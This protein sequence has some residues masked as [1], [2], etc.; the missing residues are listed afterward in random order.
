METI[1]FMV[2][3]EHRVTIHTSSG[4]TRTGVLTRISPT[5]VTLMSEEHG[6]CSIRRTSIEIVETPEEV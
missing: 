1:D 6:L 2:F 4:K 3:K 5:L